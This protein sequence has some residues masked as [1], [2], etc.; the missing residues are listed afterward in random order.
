MKSKGR[1][2]LFLMLVL[3]V[4]L[5]FVAL[6]GIGADGKW[7]AAQIKQGLDL[8]GGVYIVYEADKENVTQEEMNAAVS[9]I[10][11][12]LDWNGWTEAEVAQDG[13]NRI[14]VDIPG[15][16][17]AEEAIREI[18]QTAQLAFKDEAG[19][20][21]LTGDMVV[22]ATK[23]V[24]ATSKNGPS[25]PYVALEFSDEGKQL[26]AEATKANI[27]KT[28]QIVM[29][30]EII[31]SPMVST[32]ITDGNAII[33][34][35]F[36]GESAEEL[37]SLIRA[38]S[39]PFN[40]N[41]IHM[42]NVGARLGADALDSGVMA[43]MVGIALVLLFMLVVYKL[44]GLA[45]DIALVVYIGLEMVLL[46]AFGITLTLPGIAGIILSIGM[47]VD[48]NVVIFERI[49]E[50]L[51]EGKTLRVSVKNGFSRALPAILDG[52]I[53]TLIAAVVLFVF[54]SGTVKGFATTLMMGIIISMFTA[55]CITRI[56]VNGFM[57]SG[58]Y[59][60]KLYGLRTK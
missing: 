31:S 16:E 45:A 33:T 14:R 15:V 58:I 1:L 19:N 44:L 23:Q 34:G 47:A 52:N 42:K 55:L 37:A 17:N 3:A 12:R 35:N 39:L 5:S 40:L 22:N 57:Y 28:I 26:F 8:S 50:E 43:G 7:S 6:R 30:D 20:V 46:S 4:G 25:E 56:L 9:L 18:G 53:T 24:G 10:Q 36:T 49:K 48:A 60:P 59:N 2:M 13:S 41:V 27:G 38:G 21:L 54:G 11:G 29:D 51:V 32:E